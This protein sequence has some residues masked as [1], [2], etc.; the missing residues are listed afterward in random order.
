MVYLHIEVQEY[1]YLVMFWAFVFEEPR[2]PV[3]KT[4]TTKPLQLLTP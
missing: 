3:Q 2:N 1:L 4:T